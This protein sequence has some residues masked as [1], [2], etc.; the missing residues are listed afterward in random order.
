MTKDTATDLGFESGER[1]QVTALFYDMVGSTSM[2]TNMDIED[3]REIQQAV[4]QAANGAIVSNGGHLDLLMGDGGSAYFGYPEADEDAPQRAVAAGL[5]IL[6]E[7]AKIQHRFECAV[8]IRVGIATGPAVAGPAGT[9]VLADRNEI[10]G[11]AP[12]LAARIQGQAKV[13]TVLA[14]NATYKATRRQYQYEAIGPRELKGFDD[15][16][17]LWRPFGKL[18]T[19]DRFKTLRDAAQPFLA[20]QS[21][22]QLAQA[23]L[24]DALD[25]AGQIL[26]IH[27]EPGI[28]K[29]RLCHQIVALTRREG[30]HFLDFQ[31]E[32]AGR[33]IP[34]YPF[35][36]SLRGEIQRRHPGFDFASPSA[37]AIKNVLHL[38][39]AHSADF[40]QTLAFLLS[41]ETPSSRDVEIEHAADAHSAVE[42]IVDAVLAIASAK[43]CVIKV[44][45]LHWADSQTLETMEKFQERIRAAPVFVVV[46]SRELPKKHQASFANVTELGLTR[47]D[48]GSIRAMVES[49][50][51]ATPFP[52]R[53]VEAIVTR[54]EGVPLFAE[55][56]ARFVLDRGVDA[57]IKDAAWERLFA[58]DET[59]SLQDL[60]AARLGALGPAKFVA[61]AA[62][63]IGRSFNIV[64][65]VA[66]LSSAGTPAVAE[67]GI[68]KLVDGGFIEELASATEPTF[69]F[70]HVL[71]Q[72]AAYV[73]LLRSN[74]RALHSALYRLSTGKS[75]LHWSFTSAE[76]ALHAEEARLPLEAARHYIEAARSASSHS[77]LQE[78]RTLLLR[79][80]SLAE[81]LRDKAVAAELELEIVKFLGP[82][83]ASMEGP[84]SQE[85]SSLYKRGVELLHD[86]PGTDRATGFPLYWG[87]W[88]TGENF[89]VQRERAEFLLADMAGSNNP[90]V[91]L[92][93]HHCRWA[94]AFNLGNHVDCL[95][96]ISNG[97]ALYSED[98][99]LDHRTRYGGHDA[100]V[101][102]LGEQALSSWF[103][104]RTETAVVHMNEADDW[105]A[106]IDH[107][108]SK[109]HALD[110]GIMLYRYRGDIDKV[111]GLAR[112]MKSAAE[113]H[114]L[115]SLEAKSLIFAGWA[116]GMA[117]DPE[118]G[119]ATLTRG[120]SIQQEIGTEEDFPVYLEMAGE[121]D[122]LLGRWEDGI[123]TVSSA[124]ER[125]EETGHA[126]WLAELYRR[127][128]RLLMSSGRDKTPALADLSRADDVASRQ[129][130]RVLVL[131]AL[132]DKALLFPDHLEQDWQHR[133]RRI[134]EELEPGMERDRSVGLLA[135]MLE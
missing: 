84:G 85:A 45:D 22:L 91:K 74:R 30:V 112:Q 113:E 88:F 102:G 53:L 28:G 105:A 109:C 67:A 107:V 49:F 68:Q 13:G 57:V 31:C 10:I 35:V 59:A 66:L 38:P 61:Q 65:L 37:E 40:Y 12:T 97:L 124:I 1:I 87:W 106:H 50:A 56:L 71:L 8:Q 127:R 6:E 3:Y 121:L 62:S 9:G 77:A 11:I 76:M 42:T 32:P 81:K 2:V 19:G 14:S 47:L 103:V 131:R 21:E 133:I 7:C 23:R 26:H 75:E 126:F 72:Q 125:A 135:G 54:S 100:R 51:G 17:T 44:E 36:K 86:L 82:V 29:S 5:A 117:H 118:R 78:A 120:L 92:Q 58:S 122:G 18:E 39:G 43:P 24:R 129:N 46:T 123:A 134:L 83:V 64:T 111:A 48:A 93:A 69:R 101:C 94:T 52:A 114:D 89:K 80:L 108:G 98:E 25:G 27:G 15:L 63:V 34:F 95:E 128:A 90:E 20:R 16:Q 33:D 116:E 115:K 119:R 130:A 41:S 4:H 99:A 73:G 70:R 110:I 96:A 55:E 132:T 104:G 79:A 60:L